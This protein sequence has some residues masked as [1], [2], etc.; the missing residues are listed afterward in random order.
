MIE[1]RK[2][3]GTNYFDNPT[4]VDKISMAEIDIEG[5]PMYSE[6]FENKYDSFNIKADDYRLK[7]FLGQ[8]ET[9]TNGDNIHDFL[10][11]EM[12]GKIV[13]CKVDF[14][15]KVICGMLDIGGLEF[16]KSY[17]DG[18]YGVTFR[19]Y[20][21]E[22]ELRNFAQAAP[23][24]P[25]TNT[26]YNRFYMFV[27]FF[28]FWTFT[29][30]PSYFNI[31]SYTYID[32][33]DKIGFEPQL[34]HEIW[35]QIVPNLENVTR[36]DIFLDI[37][38]AFGLVF[39]MEY[40]G[41]NSTY[42]FVG[43]TLMFRNETNGD[44]VEIDT[45][46]WKQ[47]YKINTKT[48][49]NIFFKFWYREGVMIKGRVGQLNDFATGTVMFGT[50]F[51]DNTNYY[52]RDKPLFGVPNLNTPEAVMLN[53]DFNISTDPVGYYIK[54]E[55]TEVTIPANE[56]SEIEFSFYS[57][58]SYVVS[59]ITYRFVIMN[60]NQTSFLFGETGAGARIMSFGSMWVRPGYHVTETFIQSSTRYLVVNNSTAD[61]FSDMKR[62][63][64]NCYNQWNFLLKGSMPKTYE[65][66]LNI[67]RTFNYKI[68]DETSIEGNP[69]VL[70]KLSNMNLLERTV[71]SYWQLKTGIVI[72]PID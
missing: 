12:D 22:E 17:A 47:G 46:N 66:D 33:V 9:S 27:N 35:T 44:T 43:M 31:D 41:S 10:N 14:N 8:P 37:L 58:A 69:A 36:W 67:D 53:P 50:M 72:F 68:F 3:E 13:A 29:D 34:V 40:A 1:L 20:G 56:V 16:D 45:Q 49:E 23:V 6:E 7:C 19:V 48:N 62:I 5:F 71:K 70:Y 11:Y 26:A 24:K 60:F 65:F 54:Q 51:G 4:F 21:F 30:K 64:I 55:N 39:K 42:F 28:L 59:G 32:W 38:K 25:S 63:F 2:Y 15:G 61:V 52:L 18:E 57:S